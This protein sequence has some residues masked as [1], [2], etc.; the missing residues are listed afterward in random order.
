MARTMALAMH[1]NDNGKVN[2]KDHDNGNDMAITMARTVIMARAVTKTMS[3]A[4]LDNDSNI[5]NV[6]DD[7]E[8]KL[9]GDWVKCFPIV[10]FLSLT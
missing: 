10:N 4:V 7:Q 9:S 3:T 8:M 5:D 6:N 1:D 2:G